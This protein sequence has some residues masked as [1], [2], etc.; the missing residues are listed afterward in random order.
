MCVCVSATSA[1]NFPT[2]FTHA[3]N[4]GTYWDASVWATITHNLL[5]DFNHAGNAGTYWD[6]SVL[7]TSIRNFP[8]DRGSVL[9]I[10]KVCDTLSCF[11][12]IGVSSFTSSF[13]IGNVLLPFAL[14][15]FSILLL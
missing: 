1:Q 11:H 7:A 14:L 8:N 10:C 5:T 13:C 4:A 12:A 6:V 3:G 2:D 15:S 9:G